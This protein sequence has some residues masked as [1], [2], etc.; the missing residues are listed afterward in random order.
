[1]N[2]I[3]NIKAHALEIATAYIAAHKTDNDKYKEEI[4]EVIASLDKVVEENK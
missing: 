2:N 4:K 3:E 1:M